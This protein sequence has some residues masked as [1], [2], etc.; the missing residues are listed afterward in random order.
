[1]TGPR[2]SSATP[3][4]VCSTVPCPVTRPVAG[5]TG[6][7]GAATAGVEDAGK[8][9]PRPGGRVGEPQAPSTSAAA[10]VGATSN[11]ADGRIIAL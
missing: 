6:G 11:G 4:G 2:H 3:P 9:M 8:V 1:M 5:G 10:S 7:T